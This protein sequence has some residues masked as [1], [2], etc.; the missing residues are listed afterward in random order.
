M[1]EF[2]VTG[3]CVPDEHYMVNI[4]E[5]LEHI[6]S[7]INSGDYFTINLSPQFGKTTTLNLLERLLASTEYICMNLSF[8][9][10]GSSMFEN[11]GVFCE[12]FITQIANA[13]NCTNK[14]LANQWIDK[15]ITDFRSLRR[16][17]DRLCED[18]KIVL[19]I[20]DIDHANL[21]TVFLQ[22][23]SMLRILFQERTVGNANS[24]HSVI[25]VGVHDVKNIKLEEEHYYAPWNIATCFDVDMSFSPLEIAT[26][27]AAYEEGHNTGMNITAVSDEI[28]RFTSG[29]PHLISRICRFM[30]ENVNSGDWTVEGVQ[31]VAHVI[32]S[33]GDGCVLYDNIS[34]SLENDNDIYKFI[35]DVLVVG[36]AMSF[37]FY[38][39][40]NKKCHELGL[41]VR[42]SFGL[43]EISN[44]IFEIVL[45]NYFDLKQNGLQKEDDYA[46]I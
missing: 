44:K 21:N 4:E 39:S 29:H 1:R 19:L 36:V 3:I 5:K 8:K 43:V 2:N 32:A 27:L 20:D 24:F 15:S 42:G 12:K 30:D 40:T 6:M 25:L 45:T 18:K 10:E 28:Y 9:N 11:G 26:M 33:D 37:C 14:D 35:Y 17:I 13:L 22:F 16:H 34:K 31:S 23:L 46:E 7:F 41:I 38:E